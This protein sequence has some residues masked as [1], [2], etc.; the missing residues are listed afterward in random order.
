ME[1]R[2]GGMMRLQEICLPLVLGIDGFRHTRIIGNGQRCAPEL[3]T[4]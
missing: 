1:L 2:R 4:S 3:L